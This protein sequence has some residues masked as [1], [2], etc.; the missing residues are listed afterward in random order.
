[1]MR[2]VPQ[3]ILCLAHLMALTP[4][5]TAPRHPTN[6]ENTQSLRGAGAVERTVRHGFAL[7]VQYVFSPSLQSVVRYIGEIFFCHNK[8]PRTHLSCLQLHLKLNQEALGSKE[9]LSLYLHI[10]GNPAL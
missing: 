4:A 2:F 9:F 3:R 10:K 1:M 7:L 8:K 6:P 5:L